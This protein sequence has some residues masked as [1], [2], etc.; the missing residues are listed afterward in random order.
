LGLSTLCAAFAVRDRW[1]RRFMV[2][3]AAVTPAIALVYFYPR[4]SIPLL[5]L[6]TPWLVTTPGTLLL[7]ARDFRR[8]RHERCNTVEH[9]DLGRARVSRRH[10]A[11]RERRA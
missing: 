11:L 9:E 4:F 10:D 8:S 5:L 1:L 2:A 7:L 6:G 3:N